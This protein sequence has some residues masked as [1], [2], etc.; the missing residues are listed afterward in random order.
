[1]KLRFVLALSVAS[2]ATAATAA[3]EIVMHRDPGCGCCEKW[4]VQ[5]KAAFG[6]NV[7]VIDDANRGAYKAANGVP[8]GLT[9]CH[10]AM[11]DGYSF[12]G[13]VPIADMKRL[14]ATHPKG[15]RGLAVTGMPMGSAGMEMAGIAADHYNVI[16]FGAGKPTLFARH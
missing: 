4:A 16:A 2:I 5:V 3:R 11:I 13:H 7:R 8:A 15:V 9:S 10:T 14:I 12:E 6:R 1:M